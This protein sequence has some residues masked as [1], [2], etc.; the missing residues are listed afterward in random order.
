MRGLAQDGSSVT[1]DGCTVAPTQLQFGE[2]LRVTVTVAV[3][4]TGWKPGAVIIKVYVPDVSSPPPAM[5]SIP[6]MVGLHTSVSVL[7]PDNVPATPLTW[8]P[9]GSRTTIETAVAGHSH[10]SWG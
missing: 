9:S 7:G 10:G 5:Q 3:T 8:P 1:V 2:E 4:S 6:P